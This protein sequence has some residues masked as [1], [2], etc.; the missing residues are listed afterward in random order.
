MSKKWL[1]NADVGE[2]FDD[3]LIMPYLDCANVACGGHAGDEETMRQALKL[4]KR[5]KVMVGAQPGYP[6]LANF[7]RVS[8]DFGAK[9]LMRCLHNQIATLRVMAERLDCS[10]AYVKPHGALKQDMMTNE[11]IFHTICIMLVAANCPNV[12]VVPINSGRGWQGALAAQYSIDVWWEVSADGR[13]KADGLLCSRDQD[14]AMYVNS[15]Q[16][17]AQIEQ[18]IVNDTITAIDGSLL[19]AADATT[20]CIQGDYP[21]AVGAIKQWRQVSGG[22]GDGR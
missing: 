9:E 7:G 12:L 11:E 19:S 3:K 21:P 18:I 5:Y 17:V 14:E 10:L 6:D 4:A 13:Y 1:I 20:I 15:E 2:G 22:W 8:M 16:I